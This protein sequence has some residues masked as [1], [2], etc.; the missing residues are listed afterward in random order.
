MNKDK[1]IKQLKKR[2]ERLNKQLAQIKAKLE[3]KRC[4]KDGRQ[5]ENADGGLESLKS[6]WSDAIEEMK[7]QQKEC[8]KLI[9]ELQQAR[10][11]MLAVKPTQLS[12]FMKRKTKT[13]A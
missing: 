12:K 11:E 5:T 6:S 9:D 7:K 10:T 13:H 8:Q 3:S 2:N 4:A 1:Q